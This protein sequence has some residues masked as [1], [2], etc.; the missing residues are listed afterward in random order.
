[1]RAWARLG[2]G[3]AATAAAVTMMAA[4]PAQASSSEW[5]SVSNQTKD[6]GPWGDQVGLIV[7]GNTKYPGWLSFKAWALAPAVG[8]FD[9][10]SNSTTAWIN[11]PEAQVTC[12]AGGEV[13]IDARSTFAWGGQYAQGVTWTRVGRGKTVDCEFRNASTSEVYR[14]SA[15]VN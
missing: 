11:G 3:C 1:M 13:I 14:L 8:R 9:E 12:K 15:H 10:R 6:W 2:A 7:D 5:F 4:P